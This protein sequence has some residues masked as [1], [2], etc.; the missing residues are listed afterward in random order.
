[1]E[2]RDSHDLVEVRQ[3]QSH[4][5]PLL[6]LDGAPI[7][8]HSSIKDFQKGHSHYLAEVLEQPI[9]LPKDMNALEKMNQTQLFLSLKRDV[10]LVRAIQLIFFA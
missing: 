1:M 10:A 6:E 2:S 4:W 5:S 3:A 8:H 9:L 7:P